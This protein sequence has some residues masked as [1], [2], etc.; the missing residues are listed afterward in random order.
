MFL[1]KDYFEVKV[2]VNQQMQEEFF[3]F[4]LSG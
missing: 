3:A 2:I 4:L 1:L